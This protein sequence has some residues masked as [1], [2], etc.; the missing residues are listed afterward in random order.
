[1]NLA[2]ET[3]GRLYKSS[4]PVRMKCDGCGGKAS[5][6][7][8]TDD[9]II[10]D[11]YDMYELEKTLGGGFAAGYGKYF[12]L[13]VVDGITLPYLMKSKETG[14]CALLGPDGKCRIYTHRPGFCRL[15]PL[16]RLYTG[17]GFSY[18]L[19][20]GQC[21][22]TMPETADVTVAGWL[23]I[24]NLKKYEEYA[25][26]WHKLT[27]SRQKAAT[28]LAV[29]ASKPSPASAGRKPGTV[30]ELV[31][32]SMQL[33]NIFYVRDYDLSRDFYEQYY[34]RLEQITKH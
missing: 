16:G 22:C 26:S 31:A 34:E 13:R 19:Q 9:T 27:E 29:A 24:E 20:T 2:A 30:E 17:D 28:E 12:E 1:M 15:F 3:D 32:L 14:A 5:C 4:D 8:A 33:L 10:L 6:C 7:R 21:P 11:P 18:I 25:L 23:G